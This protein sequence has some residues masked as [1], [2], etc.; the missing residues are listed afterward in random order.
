MTK[1]NL[2][3]EN[4]EIGVAVLGCGVVGGGVAQFLREK[5]AVYSERVGRPLKLRGVAVRDLSR[6]RGLPSSLLT[7]D[8]LEL[9]R[10]EDVQ[11]VVELMGGVS[12][13]KELILEAL[14]LGKRVITANKEVIAKFG[15]E[16]F[17]VANEHGSMIYLE[18]SVGGGI[19]IVLPLKRSLVG[20]RIESI[21]GI[22]NGTTNYILSRMSNKGMG[23]AEALAEA[24]ELGF[25]EADPTSDVDGHDA[26]YKIAI[27]ATLFLGARVRA[28]DV[29]REGIRKVSHADIRYA[30]ELGYAIKLLGIAK[31]VESESGPKLDIRVHPTMTP[32]SHPL[33]SIHGATNAIAVR[34]D[35]VGEVMFSGPGAGRNPTAS[36]VL[37]DVINAAT[38]LGHLDELML[39]H[40]HHTAE[41]L[42]IEEISSRFYLRILAKDQ[43]GVLGAIGTLFGDR[44]VSVHYFMQKE[45]RDGEAVLVIVTHRVTEGA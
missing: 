5:E 33:A 24:Q 31:R 26:A 44:G 29:Y 42:P 18:G 16:L 19:P 25:A 32:L 12:P 27:L 14:R 22:I 23:F 45:A 20:N 6:D 9:I 15:A 4:R 40:H 28:E 34:G 41:Y 10:R 43:P 13:A 35:A 30:Q 11:I 38:S 21:L 39:C 2:N 36:A 3:K 1:D 7:A 17:E 8:P 37:G